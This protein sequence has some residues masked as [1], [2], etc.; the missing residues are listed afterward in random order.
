MYGE[1][2]VTAVSIWT[3]GYVLG[4]CQDSRRFAEPSSHAQVRSR[5]TSSSL[6]SRRAT[7]SLL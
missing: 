3:V 5:A 4:E 7:S 6:E 1:E 2:L